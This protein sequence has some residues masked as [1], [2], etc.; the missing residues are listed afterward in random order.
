MLDKKGLDLVDDFAD[1]K[2]GW[3]DEPEEEICCVVAGH[4]P[5]GR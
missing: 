4:R 5:Q 2:V 3:E 1:V